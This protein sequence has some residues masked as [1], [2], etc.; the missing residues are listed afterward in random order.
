MSCAAA[1]ARLIP[2]GS[3]AQ[4]GLAVELG[5]WVQ[6]ECVIFG[7]SL[8]LTSAGYYRAIEF[9]NFGGIFISFDN[10]VPTLVGTCHSKIL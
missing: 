2:S 4:L 6:R 9:T 10:R 8:Q 3:P 5:N 7:G 1:A